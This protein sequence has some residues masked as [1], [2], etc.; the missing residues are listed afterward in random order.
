MSKTGS[1]R[2][3]NGEWLKISDKPPRLVDAYVPPGGYVDEHLGHYVDSKYDDIPAKFVPARI[4][5]KEQKAALMRERGIV[6][7][8]GF[9]PVIRRKY[10]NA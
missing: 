8:G 7:D 5:S 10:F 2:F 1:Y 9:K 4:E 6:E 3:I